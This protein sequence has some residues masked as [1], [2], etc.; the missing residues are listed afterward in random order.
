VGDALL[1]AVAHR[2]STLVRPGDTLARFSGDEFV[3]LC[4]E[5][6]R[7]ADVELLAKRVEDAFIE[8]FTLGSVEVSMSAS[9]GIAYGGHGED[10][11]GALVA[12]ADIAMYQ[13]K[14]KGGANHQI[15]D[16]TEA[17]DSLDR[18]NLEFDLRSA[19]GQET[20]D[21]AYQPVINSNSGAV[22][23]VEALLRWT[24]PE[25]GSIPA[26]AMIAV[27]EQSG[28]IVKIG[29]W[30]LERACRDRCD[31]MREY[32]DHPLDLSV[33]IS[34][35]QLM[36]PEFVN[37]VTLI[38]HRTGMDPAALILEITENIFIEDGDHAMTVLAELKGL[39]VRFALDDF[40]TGYSSLSYLSQLPIDI[41]KIDQSFVAQINDLTKSA[42]IVAAVTNLA[43][44][45]GLVVTAEGVETEEQHTALRLIGCESA[46][47]YFYYRPM[48]APA[49]SA[50]LAALPVYTN[51]TSEAIVS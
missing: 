32:P 13:A 26:V 33:N 41:L 18:D 49:I 46:Q 10:V 51:L 38:L 8:P 44:V 25:R 16:L 9:V 45:L 6:R 20:L 22:T 42:A 21:L 7:P 4:E 31:W 28:L 36:S 14:R 1:V 19:F 23:G 35:R 48:S 29:G 27:A 47:G 11:S 30:V 50:Y 3:F 34:A 43:H 24:H 5:L 12:K 2:L 17:S 40:G 37:A 15:I 39:G